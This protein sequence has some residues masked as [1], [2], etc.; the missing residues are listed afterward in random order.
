MLPDLDVIYSR[1]I[2]K[3]HNLLLSAFAGEGIKR[4]KNQCMVSDKRLFYEEA[5]D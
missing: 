4:K 1:T 5:L 2:V 3:S